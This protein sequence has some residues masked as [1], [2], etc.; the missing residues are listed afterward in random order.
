M[1]YYINYCNGLPLRP[2]EGTLQDAMKEADNSAAYTQTE[3]RI[4]DEDGIVVAYRPWWGTQPD[5]DLE[6][7][8]ECI[9]FGSSGYYGPW[10]DDPD[11][12]PRDGLGEDDDC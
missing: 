4:Q 10:V 7:L 3:I 11:A 5:E 8:S 6:D 9:R 12:L 2:V 1:T